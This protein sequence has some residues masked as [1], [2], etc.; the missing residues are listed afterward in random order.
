MLTAITIYVCVCLKAAFIILLRVS[1]SQEQYIWI[2]MYFTEYKTTED[3]WIINEDKQY[4][5]STESV[6]MEKGREFCKRNFGD[7][8]VIES[9]SERKFL[10]RY[11]RKIINTME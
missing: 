11:V 5:F 4:Y 9:E 3:G 1:V 10:W 6:P 8:A 2:T 7:L